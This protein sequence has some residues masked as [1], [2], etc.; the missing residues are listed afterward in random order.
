LNYQDVLGVSSIFICFSASKELRSIY[1]HVEVVER[2]LQD[3]RVNS[4]TPLY[5]AAMNG[6]IDVVDRLLEDTRVDPTVSNNLVIR[7]AYEY[8]HVEVVER[9]LQDSRVD[10]IAHNNWVLETTS[11]WLLWS[12][13]EVGGH[14]C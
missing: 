7:K 13:R 6:H 8:G 1:G 9:L 12:R 2:L 10:P 4:S 3:S 5:W 14:S 11:N